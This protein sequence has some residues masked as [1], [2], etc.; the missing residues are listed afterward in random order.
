M[1]NMPCPLVILETIFINIL[2]IE[3]FND[4][5]AVDMIKYMKEYSIGKYFKNICLSSTLNG[6]FTEV[7][8]LWAWVGDHLETFI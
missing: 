5:V 6:Q 1:Q 3:I 4:F 2:E 8:Q 7:K